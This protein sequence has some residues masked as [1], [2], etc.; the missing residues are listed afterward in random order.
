LKVADFSNVSTDTVAPGT[1]VT[2]KT[3]KGELVYTI[4][5]ELDSDETLN[6]ISCRTRLAAALLGKRTGDAVE[7][8]AEKGVLRATVTGISV[9]D[10]AVRAWL[11]A[12]P[13]AH[14]VA[15]A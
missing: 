8:P 7:L 12:I 10:D 14:V 15:N 3:D 4:L 5:G 6:I 13:T 1:R 2:L 11:A 9:M